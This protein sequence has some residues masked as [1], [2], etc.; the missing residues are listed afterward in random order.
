MNYAL[1]QWHILISEPGHELKAGDGLKA[2]GVDQYVPK[3][4]KAQRAGRGA[5]RI[6]PKPMFNRYLFASL[7]IGAESWEQIRAIPG[8]RD[9]LQIEGA[10]ASL[11]DAAIDVIRMT[12]ADI[13][14]E[15]CR[16]FSRPPASEIGQRVIVPKGPFSE[17]VGRIKSM[18]GD[19]AEVLL[20]MEILG[21]QV[22][23]VKLARLQAA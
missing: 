12:E 10:P 21:R 1:Y 2:R 5:I 22:A 3:V 7:P 18:K 16:Q 19:R 8:V 13:E 9:F 4:A 6:V 15:R 23:Q 11:P 20:E 14:L 17:L